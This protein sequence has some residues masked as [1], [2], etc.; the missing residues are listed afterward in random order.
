M[1]LAR[2]TTVLY[3]IILESNEDDLEDMVHALSNE[4]KRYGLLINTEKTKT[5][6]LGH[7]EIGRKLK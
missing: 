4:A 2:Y 7:K 1:Q 6:M 5:M 3:K